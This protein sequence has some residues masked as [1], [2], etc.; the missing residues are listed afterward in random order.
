MPQ[1]TMPWTQDEQNRFTTGEVLEKDTMDYNG[2]VQMSI[3]VKRYALQ[4]NW[5]KVINETIKSMVLHF[6][7]S[8]YTILSSCC[9]Y[10]V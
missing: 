10:V 7:L 4:I 3:P 8:F 1:W 2:V 9:I 6:M 5:K